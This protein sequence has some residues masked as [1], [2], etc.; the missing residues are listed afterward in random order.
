MDDNYQKALSLIQQAKE[1][2]LT[3][4]YIHLDLTEL[5]P[6]IF[7]LENLTEL[8]LSSN[9]LSSLPDG[10]SKLTDLTKLY[11]SSNQLSSLPDG[12]SKLTDLTELDL[13]SNQLSSLPDDISKLTNLT[14]LYLI[15]NQ[16][17]SLPDDISKLTDLT[18]LDL[19]SNQLSSLPDGISKLTNLTELDLSSNQL[20]SLPDD[21]SKLTDLTGLYLSSNQLS[22][23]PDGISKLTGLTWLY[24]SS[25]QLSS[26]PDGISKLTGLTG[27]YL[28]SNQLSSL[29]DGIS[30]L[31]NLT[32]LYLNSNQLSSLPDGISKLTNLTELDL[33]SNQLSSLP[34]GISKLTNL[35]EL[36]LSSNQLSSLPDGISKLTNLTELYLSSNQLSS[37]PDGIS[38]LT[39]L[40]ELDLSSNQ[41]SSLPDG[42][43][44]LTNLTRLYLSSNQFEVGSEIYELSAQDQIKEILKW[45][46]AQKAGTLQPIHEAKVIF[47]GESNHGKTH[48]I[49]L[50][51]EECIKRKITTTHGIERSKVQIGCGDKDI[52]LNI[53]DLGGQEFMR[54]THQF[55]FSERSLYVLVTLAR[56]ER[57]ELNHWLKLANQLGN[58]APVLVVINK[59][60]IDPH[61]L[62]RKGLERDYPNI[63]GFVRTSIYDCKEQKATDSLKLLKNRI[64]EIVGD[65][66]S[67][68]GV[69]EQRP[70]DWFTVKEELEKLEEKGTHFITYNEYENLEFIKDLPEE[71]RKSNLKLLSM[72]GAVVSYVDDPRLIDTNVINP[73]WIMD[74]VY[75]II[76][77]PEVKDKNKGRLHIGDLERILSK[78]KFPKERHAYLLEL[79]NKFDLCY[80]AK[81]QKDVYFIPDLFEDIEPDYEWHGEA[82]IHFRYYYDDFPPDA[83]MTRFIVEMHQDIIDEKRWR[84]GVY[85]S[86]GS[87]QA[88]VYQTYSKNYIH[89]EVIGNKGEG[90]SYLYTIRESFR[91]LHEP[92]PQMQIK[93]EV[94]YKGHWL[95]YLELIELENVNE[96]QYHTKLKE[97]LPVTDILNGYSTSIDRSGTQKHIKIFLA[98]SAELKAEREQFEI[99]IHRENQQL[100]KKGIFIELQLWEN[101]IDAMSPTRLQD[102]YNNVVKHSDIFVSLFFTKVGKFT[103]EEFKAAFGQ[104]KNTGKPLVYTYFKEATIE[105]GTLNRRD[106]NSVFDFQDKLKE[107]GHFYTV[108]NNIEGLQLHFKKQLEKIMDKLF[109]SEP[110]R[111]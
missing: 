40:T 16:L 37:L 73:Q 70:P 62:D 82:S 35:T 14:G 33:S 90:R 102:E 77:D 103:L 31:T 52:R 86:N 25:N 56:R 93:Q 11:L 107:L 24:L 59:I 72:L 76:N 29:P 106:A 94:L 47:I 85:I 22:S 54:S 75:A 108:Y 49:E 97:R 53:W 45:Q 30:K 99:F 110:I 50:L 7:E 9:Q 68:P 44:K 15:S 23:L 98:S 19:S 21:I 13:S 83:F 36:Y 91:K 111:L 88:K 96:T 63:V 55:F 34:D 64:K 79:M 92:F 28:N 42:I 60:D 104:F 32:G 58:K 10:I 43:S 46:K 67:M 78:K 48:L 105:S 5:P 1:K 8:D 100:Y 109:L 6:E 71:E 81:D 65:K 74:G 3:E 26:L 61:D 12:I 84:S 2:N 57:N 27:L 39:N 66:A 4:L 20:S 18:E 51:K 38:K 80:A 101:F 41:L 69:F 95:D 89:I 17:S 87:C